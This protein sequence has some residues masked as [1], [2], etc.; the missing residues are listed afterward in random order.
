MIVTMMK[1]FGTNHFEEGTNPFDA[2]SW[3]EDLEKKFSATRYPEEFKKDAKLYYLEKDA[4]GWWKSTERHYS[5]MEPTWEE[6]RGEFERKYFPPEARDRL[7]AKFMRLEKGERSVREIEAK[8]TGLHRY[9]YYGYGDK[10]AIIRTF[11][12][13]LSPELRSHLQAVEFRLYLELVERAVDVYESLK[14]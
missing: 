1:T 11:M 9:V 12:Q 5:H 4:T 8:F 2:D 6:L 10:R 3:L 7:E 14:A 13:G